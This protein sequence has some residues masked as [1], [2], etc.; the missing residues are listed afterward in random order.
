MSTIDKREYDALTTGTAVMRRVD[1]GVLVLTDADRADFLQR[2]TTNNISA[3]QSGESTVTVLT[4]PM[5]RILY[6]FGVVCRADDLLL[7]PDVGQ[8]EALARHLRSQIFFMDNVKVADASA[9][10]QRVRV[11][12]PTATSTLAAI[13]FTLDD[14]AEGAWQL[15]HEVIAVKQDAYDVSGVELVVP[16]AQVDAVIAQLIEAGGVFLNDDAAYNAR[17]V[18][19]GRP[20]VNHEIG[21]PYTPLE[22]G[23]AWTCAENKGCYTGQEIIA[24]QITYDKVT[25]TLVGLR[26]DAMLS[27]GANVKAGGT[28]SVG[29]VT[30]VAYSP[31]LDAPIALAVVKRPHNEPATEVTIDD[32]PAQVVAFP[33]IS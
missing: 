23:L 9:E 14:A 3:L 22:S 2:M 12:G 10:Y 33:F 18:E 27:V 15:S 26:S 6:V 21:E 5:A 8:T 31:A 4:N 29:D 25:K 13:G 7:L 11:M 28:R 19:L 16:T 32:V 17:R 30:S 24:R 1:A 20:L